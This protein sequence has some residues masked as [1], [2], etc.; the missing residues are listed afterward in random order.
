MN[1]KPLKPILAAIATVAA[2]GVVGT[3]A[4]TPGLPS[5]R[6]DPKETSWVSLRDYSS[7]AFAAKFDELKS[8]MMV[9]D[10]DVD[11]IGGD[12]RVG[13][14]FRK[15]PDGRGWVSLRDLSG[16][17]FAAKWD[18]LKAKGFRPVDQETYVAGG[19]R[20]FA[21]VW[22]ENRE[23][24]GFASYRGVD[25]AAFSAKFD[26]Y[27]DLGL[28]PVD[29]DVYPTPDG[30][31]YAAV[32]VENLEHLGWKLKRGLT[33]AQFAS[34][35]DTCKAQGF[36][37]LVVD[38]V[39]TSEGQ[40]YAGIFVENRNKRAW[41]EY[42]DL[43]ATGFRNRW[44]QLA[45]MG[46][47]LDG[48]EK[49]ETASGPRFSGVWRQNSGRPDW[50]L[51]S[52]IDGDVQKH[53]DLYKVPGISVSI[54]YKG[55]TVYQRGFG[56][57]DVADGIWMHG[58]S[59]NR[60]AS[61]SKAVAGV[62]AMR[63]EAKHPG[64]LATKV[65]TILPAMPSF[66]TY[67]VAQT[68]MNRSCVV[69][70]PKPFTDQNQTQYDSAW[71]AVKAIMAQPLGCTPGNYLYSTAAYEM[72]GASAERLELKTIDRIVLDE[73]TNRFGLTT[74]RP[75]T[76]A[77]SLDDRVQLYN[78]DNTE[79]A[80][81]N[82]S[83]KTLGGGLVASASD[84]TRFGVGILD[85]TILTAA[86]RTTMWTPIGTYGYGWDVDTAD[87][88]ERVV[89]KAGGQPGAKSYLRIYPDDG[90]VISVLSN[91]WK[92]GHSAATL[93]KQIGEQMLNALP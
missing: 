63:L 55:T 40:R 4:A 33:S 69:S 48:Y 75:E 52:T 41:Y 51:R 77:G 82:E 93:S 60:I 19:T 42:R 64:F 8:T 6:F 57:Q 11:V 72:F 39:R 49:Y 59:V 3:A 76:T 56:Y 32:W 91:R 9:I 12:Y 5:S 86:Q 38:S 81:D 37:S 25:S 34:T 61:V 66:H 28:M 84:L 65:R 43:T 10:L 35:F 89:G 44:N 30:L 16:T 53:L 74:L 87:S 26:H 24:L 20:L 45:D 92:G 47:R 27:R 1:G 88:G 7:A 54:A 2:L 17:A 31:R 79:Y 18:E 62:L 67:T 14:V 21:G 29:V 78:T 46:F 68:V 73:I 90:I 70:Y 58:N 36:R 15:N 83:N 71:L 85:G 50:K 13:A 23:H 80:G 22:I